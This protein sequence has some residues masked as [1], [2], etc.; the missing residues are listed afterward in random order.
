M[1]FGAGNRG[2]DAC[3]PYEQRRIVVIGLCGCLLWEQDQSFDYSPGKDY[4]TP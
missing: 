3:S 1:T 4:L 2:A